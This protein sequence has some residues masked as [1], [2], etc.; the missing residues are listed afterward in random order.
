MKKETEKRIERIA[1]MEKAL[2][3]LNAAL[4]SMEEAHNRWEALSEERKALTAYYYN[5]EWRDDYEADERGEL[6]PSLPRGVLS[7]DAVYNNL[8]EQ[9]GE[10][11]RMLRMATDILE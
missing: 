4:H 11:I 6:P 7:E 1:R 2:N 10:A 5:E 3:A 8:V 9:R